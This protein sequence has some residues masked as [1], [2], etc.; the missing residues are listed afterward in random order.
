MQSTHCDGGKA[1]GAVGVLEADLADDLEVVG[2]L[3][4][5][6]RLG[7]VGQGNGP[8]GH[9]DDLGAM[10]VAVVQVEVEPVLEHELLEQRAA[11][12]E[13]HIVGAEAVDLGVEVRGDE[14]RAPPELHRVDERGHAA[15]RVDE[16]T[17]RN[18][19]SMTM[20]RPAVR[21]LQVRVAANRAG[22]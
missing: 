8:V 10:L 15:D 1:L 14:A 9:L 16:R 11:E 17:Q 4:D 18:P 5:V 19:L 6:R 22:S 3:A 13:A 20:V 12:P 2:A 7:R 21:G